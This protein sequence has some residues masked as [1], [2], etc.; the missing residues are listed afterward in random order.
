MYH[1]NYKKVDKPHWRDE[2]PRYVLFFI[3]KIMWRLGGGFL[4]FH[5]S[6]VC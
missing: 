3:K 2:I 1:K 4:S 5:P 6:F